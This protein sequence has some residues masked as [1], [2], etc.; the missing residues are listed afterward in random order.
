MINSKLYFI[1]TT[2]ESRICYLWIRLYQ[3]FKITHDI[4]GINIW[5]VNNCFRICTLLTTA[6][7][8]VVC[9]GIRSTYLIH[10]SSNSTVDLH[11]IY[12]SLPQVYKQWKDDEKFFIHF[13]LRYEFY[14]DSKHTAV[15]VCILPQENFRTS[16]FRVIIDKI[17][18]AISLYIQ[19][20]AI[21][22]FIY[23]YNPH[24]NR[25]ISQM[26]FNFCHQPGYHN[27]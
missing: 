17:K 25:N 2:F 7:I 26:F 10:L 5:N 9:W 3:L 16:V 1:E 27:L 22:L 15:C 12:F 24:K 23:I 14:Y 20:I 6:V 11:N 18:T 8:Y 21:Y 13:I 4:L 19:Q